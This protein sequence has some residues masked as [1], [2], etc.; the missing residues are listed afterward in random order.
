MSEERDTDNWPSFSDEL[1]RKAMETLAKWADRVERGKATKRD[2]FVVVDS[3]WDVVSGLANEQ[4][5]RLIEAVHKE[6]ID[7][8]QA[9][10]KLQLHSG[11]R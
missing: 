9:K 4:D 10:R 11:L 1:S 5:L 3:M 6:I 2:L 7:E 8:V